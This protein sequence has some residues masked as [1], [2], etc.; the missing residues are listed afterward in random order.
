M[1]L[2]SCPGLQSCLISIESGPGAWSLRRATNYA[3]FRVNGILIP[4]LQSHWLAI[5]INRICYFIVIDFKRVGIKMA[6]VGVA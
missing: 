4:V 2:G 1:D 6:C 3:A 5:A